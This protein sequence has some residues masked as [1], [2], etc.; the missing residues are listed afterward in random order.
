M[1]C[2]SIV[3]HLKSVIL[4]DGICNLCNGAVDFIMKKDKTRQFR[5]VALQSNEGKKYMDQYKVPPQIDSVILIKNEEAFVESEAA[6]EIGKMLPAP[7]KWSGI[8]RIVPLKIR[9]SIYRWI[10]KNRYRWFGKR[11]SCR[12]L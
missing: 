12:I 11:Q 4:F 5:F 1:N 2:Y 6:I 8:F 3:D 9:D 7:W 10:A